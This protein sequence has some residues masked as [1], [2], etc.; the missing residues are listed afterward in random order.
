MQLQNKQIKGIVHWLLSPF[1]GV[2][3]GLILLFLVGITSCKKESK[4]TQ[5][6]GFVID[7]TTGVRLVGA[8]VFL[9]KQN[10][11]CFSCQGTT[12]AMEIAD[13]NGMY[14]FDFEHEQGFTY[15]LAANHTNYWD[16]VNG[17]NLTKGEKNTKIIG[18]TP[19]AYIRVFIKNVNPY[20]GDD[21]LGLAIVGGVCFLWDDGGY[22]YC[23]RS[24]RKSK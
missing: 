4:T 17:P 23:K 7:E 19:K 8:R 20:D 13:A 15:R 21:K 2:G 16:V 24:I 6:K 5:V 12:I 10:T 18:L 9:T 1:G 3:G 14:G 22:I 11:D